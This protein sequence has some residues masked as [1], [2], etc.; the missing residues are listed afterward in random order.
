MEKYRCIYPTFFFFWLEERRK[1][2]LFKTDACICVYLRVLPS[3]RRRPKESARV[4]LERI[5]ERIRRGRREKSTNIAKHHLSVHMRKHREQDMVTTV[6][7]SDIADV[8][9]LK[10]AMHNN[11]HYRRQNSAHAMNC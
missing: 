7:G 1:R 4:N 11:S 3:T 8:A 6:V 10:N 5:D 2:Y 9:V